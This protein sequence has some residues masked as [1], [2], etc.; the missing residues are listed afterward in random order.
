MLE[1]EEHAYLSYFKIFSLW[2]YL[3]EEA[4]QVCKRIQNMQI[5]IINFES[6]LYFS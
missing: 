4:M 1:F 5:S 3:L 6:S 2:Q